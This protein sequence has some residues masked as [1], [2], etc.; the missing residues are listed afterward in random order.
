MVQQESLSLHTTL[1]PSHCRPGW[2]MLGGGEAQGPHLHKGVCLF[3]EGTILYGLPSPGEVLLCWDAEFELKGGS[4][5][6]GRGCWGA[7]IR[8]GK[9]W[10]EAKLVWGTP[11]SAPSTLTTPTTSLSMIHR[12]SFLRYPPD[13]LCLSYLYLK[14]RTPVAS[15]SLVQ[16]L[17]HIQ[18]HFSEFPHS[19]P[20]AGMLPL[21]VLPV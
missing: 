9:Y 10:G 2:G 17:P 6:A 15:P 21:F 5:T 8:I 16:N 3:Y 18:L 14:L 19:S 12:D 11:L 4:W 1:P 20:A 13:K 7:C